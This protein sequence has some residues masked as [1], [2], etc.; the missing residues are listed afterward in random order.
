MSPSAAEKE[1]DN[2]PPGAAATVNVSDTGVQTGGRAEM[3]E[4][5]TG[6]R[7]AR[8]TSGGCQKAEHPRVEDA[9]I[10]AGMGLPD[11]VELERVP[12]IVHVGHTASHQ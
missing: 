10:L 2:G 9:F 8:H 5:G 12:A 7:A 6:T 1:A 11:T 3:R 4:R